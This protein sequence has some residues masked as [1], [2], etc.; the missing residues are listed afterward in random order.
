MDCALGGYRVA[1]TATHRESAKPAASPERTPCCW[2]QHQ[3]TGASSHDPQP[4]ARLPPLTGVLQAGRN[5]PRVKA[6]RRGPLR[7]PITVKE[8]WG[9]ARE[10][11]RAELARLFR[12]QF[13]R[14]GNKN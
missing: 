2:D 6:P 5:I 14:W 4:L 1:P 9:R 3:P 10:W 7:M 13:T 11:L 12:P 8:P